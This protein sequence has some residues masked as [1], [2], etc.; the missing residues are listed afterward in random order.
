MP[1][2]VNLNISNKTVY[3]IIT[4]L[5]VVFYR[6][7]RQVV[8]DAI[9]I[10]LFGIISI[11]ATIFGPT[12]WL[13]NLSNWAFGTPAVPGAPGAPA[14]EEAP[15]GAAAPAAG[16]G[17]A[18][19]AGKGAAPAAKAATPAKEAPKEAPKKPA[20]KGGS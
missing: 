14:A 12:G 11:L 2:N 7:V 16:K 10:V 18:P 20:E 5:V 13:V 9:G 6:P 8:L 1:A 17:V 15:A 3:G 19:A 4:F